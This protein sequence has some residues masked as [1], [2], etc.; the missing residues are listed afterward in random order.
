MRLEYAARRDLLFERLN[1]LPGISVAVKPAGA[2]YLLANV[3]GTSL[4]SRDFADRLLQEEAVSL[5]DGRY[6]GD[7]GEGL[8]RISFAQ[9]RERLEEGCERIKN[10]LMRLKA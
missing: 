5:L 6:F 4:S 9:S 8:V 3:T 1:Q 7:G 2:M 10:F